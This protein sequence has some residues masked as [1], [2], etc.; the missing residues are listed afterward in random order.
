MSFEVAVFYLFSAVLVFS[1]IRVITARNSVHSALFLV[2]SFFT[3]AAIW[4]L[5][6]AEFLAITLVLVY[7]GAVMVLFLFVVMM[8]DID[9]A[10]LR[11]GFIRNFPLGMLIG[12]VLLVELLVGIGAYR[13]GSLKLGTP[14]GSAAPSA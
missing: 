13:V 11:A 12:L 10:E 3:A 14:D 2:L 7:V 8:L 9:F 1:A 4:L 6:R 5:L